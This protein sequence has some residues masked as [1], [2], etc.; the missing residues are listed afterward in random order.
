M[1]GLFVLKVRAEFKSKQ[2]DTFHNEQNLSS[3]HCCVS[4]A[5][6]RYERSDLRLEVI[7]NL[8]GINYFICTKFRSK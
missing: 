1:G 7:N 8:I 5:N 3:F 4:V 6:S 2:R